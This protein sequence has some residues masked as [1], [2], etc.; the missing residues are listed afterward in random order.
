[1]LIAMHVAIGKYMVKFSLLISISPGSLPKYPLGSTIK[2]N[3]IIIITA[4]NKIKYL[5]ND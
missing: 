3:P 5:A 2:I 1:M 4:P